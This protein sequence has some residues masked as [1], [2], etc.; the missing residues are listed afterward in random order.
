MRVQSQNTLTDCWT[1]HEVQGSSRRRWCFFFSF[2]DVTSTVP[3]QWLRFC[4][5]TPMPITFENNTK[6]LPFYLP[7][8]GAVRVQIMTL[9]TLKKHCLVRL[10]TY[11]TKF[12]HP[13][14]EEAYPTRSF[15]KQLVQRYP[16]CPVFSQRQ[17][18]YYPN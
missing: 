11:Q 15:F 3:G 2:T 13:S 14:D 18:P 8:P 12:S 1:T 5:N 9:S 7:Q 16:L 17:T 6:F 10:E 4:T